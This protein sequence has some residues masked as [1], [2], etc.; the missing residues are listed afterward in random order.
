M[1]G[2]VQIFTASTGYP[3]TVEEA[4]QYWFNSNSQFFDAHPAYTRIAS[5]YGIGGTGFDSPTGSNPSGD[6]RWGVW[7]NSSAQDPYDVLIA[8]TSTN[9]SNENPSGSLCYLSNNKF[10][11][12]S[13]LCKR[14]YMIQE[15]FLNQISYL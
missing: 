15:D 10:E 9:P 13:L 4:C 2:I 5:Y 1:A 8:A 12:L 6:N 7:R 11:Y 3:S 14:L